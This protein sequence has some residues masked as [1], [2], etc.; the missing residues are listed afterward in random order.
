MSTKDI[1][2]GEQ[3]WL[4]AFNGGDASGVAQMY[5]ADGRLHAPNAPTM[6]GRADI[7][8]F[9]K[10]FVQTGAKLTFDGLRVHE[11]PDLC[12]AVGQ[13][14]MDFPPESGAPQDRGKFVE[15]WARQGDGSWLIVDDIFNSDVPTA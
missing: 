6:E 5:A 2:A 10:E 15:V 9:V 12:A 1:A 8:A 11:T 7:E 13:Y 4:D 14:R 3:R